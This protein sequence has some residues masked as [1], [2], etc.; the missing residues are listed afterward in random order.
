MFMLAAS[1]D[2]SGRGDGTKAAFKFNCNYRPFMD[3]L[4]VEVDPGGGGPPDFQ[5]G[6]LITWHTHDLEEGVATSVRVKLDATSTRTLVS[7]ETSDNPGTT[8]VAD[9]TFAN[10]APS[11]PH[12]VEVW[13]IDRA[14][15]VSDS[16]IIVRFDLVPPGPAPRQTRRP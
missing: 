9:S 3:S 15:F 16:S 8:F 14:G 4:T 2:C 12:S 7:N 6:R 1:R 5:D 11:N 13:A 10:L